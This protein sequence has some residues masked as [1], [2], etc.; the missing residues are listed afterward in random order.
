MKDVKVHIYDSTYHLRGEADEAYLAGLAAYVDAKMRA[1]A[2]TTRNVDSM[3]VA[4]LAALAIADELHSL[5]ARHGELRN[6]TERCLE[7]VDRALKH[8]A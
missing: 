6:R 1:V 2:E 3:R 8:S 4:V 7:L 5:R